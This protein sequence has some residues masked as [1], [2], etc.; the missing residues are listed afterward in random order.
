MTLP[1]R[2]RAG[3]ARRPTLE[4]LSR[5][6]GVSASTV[7]R[8]LK[9]DARISADM[10]QRIARLAAQAG[11]TPDALARSLAS[12]QSGLLGLVLGPVENPFYA[13]LLQEAVAQ[14]AQ[15]GLR[16]LV[17]HAGAG[18]IEGRTTEAL[19]QYRVDGCLI[20]SAELSSRAAEICAA[21]GVQVVMINR[22]AQIAASA[23]ACDNAR[24]GRDLAAFLLEGGHRRFAV[25]HAAGSSSTG[26]DRE[27]G[28][29]QA[30]AE[31]GCAVEQ[32][33]PGLSTYD[34]GFAAG[35]AIAAMDAAARPDAV[36]AVSDIMAMGVLDALRL[37]GLRV[38][39][40]ISVV[41][42]DNIAAAAR[43]IY[44]LTTLEQPLAAMVR[45]GLDLLVARI[46]DPAMPDET[47][48]LRGRLVVRGSA[49]R[50]SPAAD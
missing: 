14:A 48:T 32:R 25:V 5:L 18:P 1:P 31:A 43:P 16:F 12:G 9:N 17:V 29:V 35:E 45:R 50:L 3:A 42:F 46:A 33:L 2:R 39:E 19:L 23:V 26:N 6:A 44:R 11:Y 7:S 37:R 8:A 10:R 40:Q 22:I 41:G 4:T 34:G 28:F 15:R 21:N 38:P 13:E 49:R 24:G 30:L 47:V 20:S 36:F 27:R